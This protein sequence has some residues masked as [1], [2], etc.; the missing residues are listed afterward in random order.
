VKSCQLEELPQA[1]LAYNSYITLTNA[2]KP[3]DDDFLNL[4]NVSI[5]FVD[6]RAR[7]M[8]K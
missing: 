6:V 2:D 7:A 4:K 1:L 8:I 3:A 5:F